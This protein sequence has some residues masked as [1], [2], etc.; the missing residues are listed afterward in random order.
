[1]S[2]KLIRDASSADAPDAP[3]SLAASRALETVFVPAPTPVV[4]ASRGHEG[5]QA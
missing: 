1:M 5:A 2:L 3:E 4:P